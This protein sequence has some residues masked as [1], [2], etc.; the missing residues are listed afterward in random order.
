MIAITFALPAESA[1]LV[2]LLREKERHPCGDTQIL[3]GKIDGRSVE[4]LHT[5]VGE[6]VCRR[7]VAKF[8]QDRQ[9]NLLISAGFAGALTERLKVGDVLLAENFST[10]DIRQA[11]SLL[12]GIPVQLGR[13]ITTSQVI[14]SAEERFELA[15]SSGAAAADMETEY[16]ARACAENALPMLSL[17]V[18]SD[19]PARPLPAPP[20]ILFDIDEQKIKPTRLTVHLIAHPTAAWKLTRFARQIRRARKSLTS[21]IVDLLHQNW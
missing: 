19:S 11:E 2:R 16:V 14:D 20:R 8:L 18:I 12:S 7:R 5:G 17:R 6:K 4:I 9:F 10:A 1:G 15:R 13:L 21:A 3:R